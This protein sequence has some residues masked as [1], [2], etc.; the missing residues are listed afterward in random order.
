MDDLDIVRE[1]AQQAREV[2]ADDLVAT[3]AAASGAGGHVSETFALDARVVD[4]VTGQEGVI[5]GYTRENVI[6]P[7]PR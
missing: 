4:R 2:R 1:R 7:P 3:R 6:V 5:V